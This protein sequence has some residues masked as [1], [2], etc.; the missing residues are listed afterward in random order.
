MRRMDKMMN[1][2]IREFLSEQVSLRLGTEIFPQLFDVSYT[3]T[4]LGMSLLEV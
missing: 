2:R 4:V 3:G 1:D